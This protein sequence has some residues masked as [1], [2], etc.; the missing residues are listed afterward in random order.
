MNYPMRGRGGYGGQRR[1]NNNG[2]NNHGNYQPNNGQRQAP[3]PN[4]GKLRHNREKVSPRQP[5]MKGIC[6]V[7]VNGQMLPFFVNLW[8]NTD[9]NT[10]EESAR[11]TFVDPNSVPGQQQPQQGNYGQGQP[12]QG[13]GYNQAPQG[14]NGAYAPG[15][16]MSRARPIPAQ[17]TR[18]TGPYDNAPMPD[19]YPDGPHEYPTDEEIPF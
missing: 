7:E 18:Q 1:Q 3:K 4:T 14:Q 5:D 10:G 2:Y 9:Q 17:H 19:E 8:F 6:N 12:Y 15:G 16:A 13:H 11:L